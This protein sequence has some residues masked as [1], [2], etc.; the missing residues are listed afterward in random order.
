MAKSNLTA[1]AMQLYQDIVAYGKASTANTI[2]IN[3]SLETATITAIGAGK[4]LK[5]GDLIYVYPVL[6]S[7]DGSTGTAGQTLI[8]DVTRYVSG[9]GFVKTTVTTTLTTTPA[10]AINSALTSAGLNS[11]LKAEL[12]GTKLR[13]QAQI[14]KVGFKITGGTGLTGLKLNSGDYGIPMQFKVASTITTSATSVV[15]A[16]Y[17]L[18]NISKFDTSASLTGL[19]YECCRFLGEATG[20]TLSASLTEDIYKGSS[21]LAVQTEHSE[22]ESTLTVDELVFNVDNLDLIKGFKKR[23]VSR[24]KFSGEACTTSY[25]YGSYCNPIEFALKG[26]SPKSD[27]IG[28][29]YINADRVKAPSCE[30]PLG[31]EFRVSN[32]T[33]DV[34]ADSDRVV[35][36]I[37]EL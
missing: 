34:L 2:A 1:K 26:F 29:L 35:A 19:A 14:D 15:L 13:L 12:V 16:E 6:V 33:M 3:T 18:Y 4:Q 20:V 10:D 24:T 36:K 23:T 17:Y 25:L 27:G 21:K 37:F 9:I 28:L 22:G 7:A 8:M 32:E 11:V 31:K 5:A 30:I